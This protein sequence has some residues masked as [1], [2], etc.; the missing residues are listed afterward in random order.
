VET[1]RPKKVSRERVELFVEGVTMNEL[2]VAGRL[3]SPES[4][5]V[6]SE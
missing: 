4:G 6:G 3:V 5:K 2:E 1:K